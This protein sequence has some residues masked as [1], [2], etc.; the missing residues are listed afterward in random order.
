MSRASESG[1]APTPHRTTPI[2]FAAT[3]A[4]ARSATRHPGWRRAAGL[5]SDADPGSR[6]GESGGVPGAAGREVRAP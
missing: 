1:S 2:D 3:S 6:S 4:V 5:V